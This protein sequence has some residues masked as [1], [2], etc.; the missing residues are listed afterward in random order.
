[1]QVLADNS[2]EPFLHLSEDL[3]S[4]QAHPNQVHPLQSVIDSL[5]P[6][7]QACLDR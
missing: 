6:T 1:M 5:S 3:L 4:C 2:D 7:D